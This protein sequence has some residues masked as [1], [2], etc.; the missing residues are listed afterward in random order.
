[1]S[2]FCLFLNFCEFID[3][4]FEITIICHWFCIFIQDIIQSK[5]NWKHIK[6]NFSDKNA[7]QTNLKHKI[8]K[9]ITNKLIRFRYA[10]CI[11]LWNIHVSTV[12]DLNLSDIFYIQSCILHIST[13]IIWFTGTPLTASLWSISVP[14]Q[15]TI[16]WAKILILQNCFYN[17]NTEYK[18]R[19]WKI[20]IDEV[21]KI[22]W[23]SSKPLGVQWMRPNKTWLVH[24]HNVI[25]FLDKGKKLAKKT[26]FHHLFLCT[27]NECVKKLQYKILDHLVKGAQLYKWDQT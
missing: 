1:M 18:C 24:I 12:T 16:T 23:K 22:N 27:A 3:K 4:I 19:D 14:R 6:L 9:L 13:I 7:T 5:L 17:S 21:S 26:S 10:T 25:L 20:D 8:S 11:S 2:I 15:Y